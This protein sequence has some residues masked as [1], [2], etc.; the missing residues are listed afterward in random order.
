MPIKGSLAYGTE[1]AIAN[2]N[3]VVISNSHLG[4]DSSYKWSSDN[5]SN[6]ADATAW[7][8]YSVFGGYSAGSAKDNIVVVENSIINGNV[9]GG[10]ELQN[11][12]TGQNGLRELHSNVV[13]LHNVKIM[14]GNAVYGTATADTVIS[15][16]S[17]LNYGADGQVFFNEDELHPVNRRRGI[18]YVAGSNFADS[19]YA[20]YVHFG[21]YFDPNTMVCLI[22]IPM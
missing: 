19:V 2:N 3:V 11:Q 21:Q 15:T 1:S 9:Y 17:D 13:S 10:F 5:M 20:R 18:V 8:K 12:L 22:K 16:N 7:C 14:P 6:N 4:L